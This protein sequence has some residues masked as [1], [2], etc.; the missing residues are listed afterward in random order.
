MIA[1][2]LFVFISCYILQVDWNLVCWFS[3]TFVIMAGFGRTGITRWAWHSLM[4]DQP[5]THFANPW[6][7]VKVSLTVLVLSNIVS[8][9]PLILLM[10]PDIL[11]IPD[12][13]AITL[14]Q[15]RDER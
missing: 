4:G 8:N 6:P 1:K 9:V 7:L 15:Q 2:G 10:A 11:T 12:K 3:G 5:T 14:Q 13:G